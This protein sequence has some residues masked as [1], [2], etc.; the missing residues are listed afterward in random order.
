MP[1]RLRE[2]AQPARHLTQGCRIAN[3]GGGRQSRL[4]RLPQPVRR[5]GSAAEFRAAASSG[6]NA[7]AMPSE[8]VFS[9]LVMHLPLTC[10]P[11]V[12]TGAEIAIR[13][14][15]RTCMCGFAGGR[16]RD[17]CADDIQEIAP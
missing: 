7:R 15:R 9:F 11:H 5:L 6:A 12:A 4:R 14:L 13:P 3:S 16:C 8:C 1:R 2:L 17:E 10:R